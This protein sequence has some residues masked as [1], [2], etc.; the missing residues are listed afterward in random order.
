MPDIT[1]ESAG[2]T[3][4]GLPGRAADDRHAFDT[5]DDE[6]IVLPLEG[7]AQ[8]TVDGEAYTLEGRDD[9]FTGITDFL[10]VPR[11][12]HLEIRQQGRFALPSFALRRTNCRRSTSPPTRSPSSCAARAGDPPDQQLL[13]RRHG[14]RRQAHRGRGAHARRQLVLVSAAQARRG[15]PG[16]QVRARGDLL[17]RGRRGGIAYQRASGRAIDILAEVRRVTPCSCPTAG[18]ARRSP[19]QATTSTT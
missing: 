10:Y 15:H 12:S 6:L 5:K 11:D 7:G 14:L 3:Y 2:W 4:C 9:V 8:V 17:L 16:H 19:R 13:R 18:T 1:P